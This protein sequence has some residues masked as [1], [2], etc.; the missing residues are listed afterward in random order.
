MSQSPRPKVDEVQRQQWENE[1]AV[2]CEPVH[3]PPKNK[4]MSQV[5][6]N[7]EKS[8]VKKAH[9]RDLKKLRK[10]PPI[11][12]P[13]PTRAPSPDLRQMETDSRSVV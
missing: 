10:Q 11:P 13:Y 1:A 6:T 4:L 8:A 9:A 7:T 5:F 12:S 3:A 2:S